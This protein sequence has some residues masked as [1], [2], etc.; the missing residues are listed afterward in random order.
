M[1]A[2][3]APGFQGVFTDWEDVERIRAFYPYPKWHKCYSE[4]DAYEWIKRNAYSSKSSYVYNYGDTFSDFHIDAKYKILED[5][6]LYKFDCKRVGNIRL[7]V[8]NA[9]IEYKGTTIYVKLNNTYLSNETVS[10]HMSAIHNLLSILGDY[11]DVN[12]ELPYYSL[13]YCLT[14][15]SK[16]NSRSINLT[17]GLITSRLGAVAYSLN[18]G[19]LIEEVE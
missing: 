18:F 6:V 17:K 5:C 12:I 8:P 9:L 4:E 15:Y 14:V 13:Y 7:N 11:V 19:N 1:Y 3:V 2:I 10:G 16:G